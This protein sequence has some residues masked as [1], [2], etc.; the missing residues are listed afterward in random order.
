MAKTKPNLTESKLT[1]LFAAQKLGPMT[2]SQIV[3][4]FLENELMDYIDVQL[5]LAELTEGRLFET[6]TSAIGA[7]YDLTPLG[8]DAV[9]YFA[10][11]IPASV[12]ERISVLSIKWKQIF[13]HEGQVFADWVLSPGG[14]YV[15]HLAAR[16]NGALLFEV[17]V[18]VAEKA[19]AET[20]CEAWKDRSAQVY[21]AV[22]DVLTRP[23]EPKE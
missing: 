1:L 8:V 4:F 21:Q 23:G 6:K 16:E 13:K 5:C 22:I 3:R 19:Q 9:G 14:D 11:R 20:L 15:V 2:N 10:T 7:V 12:R 18:A 17:N